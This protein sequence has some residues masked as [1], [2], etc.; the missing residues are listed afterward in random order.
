MVRVSAPSIVELDNIVESLPEEEKEL[1]QRL[2]HLSATTGWLHPPETMHSW[3]KER[4]GSLEA[5]TSQ[6]IIKITNLVTY[7]GA[8]FN[9]LRSSRPLEIKEKLRIEAQI[10]DALK[11]ED[12][13]R[14]P[15]EDTPEDTF[16]RI[17]G[18]YS[19]TASNIAK[20]DGLH[21]IVIFKDY[22]PLY[23][24]K[25][26]ISDYLDTGWKWA[27]KARE[28]DPSAKYFLFI[29]NSLRRAGASLLHGHAQVT[30]TRSKHYA[31]I[32]GLRR[33]ALGYQDK[34][35]SNYFED[36]YRAH[37]AVGC[38]FEKEGVKILAYLTPVKEKE[39]ILLARSFDLALKERIYEVLACFRDQM[40]VTAFNF[41]LIP[42]PVAETEESW[43]GFPVIARVVDRGDPKM[44]S[45]DIGTMELYA[46][47]V[48]SSDPL[49]V[50]R[51][52]RG[53]LLT[54]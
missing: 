32:E 43:E 26:K 50:A 44:P 35:G 53:G 5:V 23:F 8:L 11:K 29:W 18:K 4:F 37:R 3:I 30:L 34:Y 36:L 52:V 54:G 39:V 47:S 24:T 22:N 2:F 51:I 40:H 9:K 16:G 28:A 21:G 31:K 27:E 45:C 20:Y 46:S 7:E 14:C 6:K 41:A 17:E 12:P 19:I 13:L 10:I 25:E 48:I 15:R 49:E 1:F 42:P 33:A 38:A